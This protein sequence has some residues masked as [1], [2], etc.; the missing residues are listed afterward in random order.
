MGIASVPK[1]SATPP[2]PSTVLNGVSK[3]LVS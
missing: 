3:E 1:L 2:L